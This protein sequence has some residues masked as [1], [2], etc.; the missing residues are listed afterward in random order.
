MDFMPVHKAHTLEAMLNEFRILV[1]QGKIVVDPK[2]SMLIHCLE[3]AVWTDKRDKLDKDVVAHHFDHLMALVYLTRMIDWEA[4]PIPRD[5]MID[6]VRVIELNFDKTKAEG[7][8]ARALE[9]AFGK[10]R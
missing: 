10:K 1:S 2:C 5:F 4:N 9:T 8:S 7:K 3:N 6:N